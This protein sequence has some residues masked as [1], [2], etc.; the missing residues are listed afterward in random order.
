MRIKHL[1]LKSKLNT[2]EELAP[3]KQD[4]LKKRNPHSGRLSV[5]NVV[6]CLKPTGT[7][8]IVGDVKRNKV[9]IHI[10]ISLFS[11]LLFANAIASSK[12]SL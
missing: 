6:L 9:S 5:K 1:K 8:I 2:V 3:V 12:A 10:F 4:S 11:K 7:Q